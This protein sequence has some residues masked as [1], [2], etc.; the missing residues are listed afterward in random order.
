MRIS[1]KRHYGGSTAKA[2]KKFLMVNYDNIKPKDD[3]ITFGEP[4]YRPLFQDYNQT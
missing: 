1:A 4:V 2:R 3:P